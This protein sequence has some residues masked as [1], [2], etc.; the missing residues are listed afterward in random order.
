MRMFQYIMEHDLG[1]KHRTELLTTQS[2]QGALIKSLRQT[3]PVAKT[4]KQGGFRGTPWCTAGQ[5]SIFLN[6]PTD[7][8]DENTTSAS[9][10][11]AAEV[12]P[13]KAGPQTAVSLLPV[14]VSAADFAHSYKCPRGT[15]ALKR[16]SQTHRRLA[17]PIPWTHTKHGHSQE[18]GQARLPQVWLSF[19]VHLYMTPSRSMFKRTQPTKPARTHGHCFPIPPTQHHPEEILLRVYGGVGILL[20]TNT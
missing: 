1:N 18:R 7:I 10:L 12:K 14:P 13:S 8:L 9:Y 5:T 3:F 15:V 16:L 4:A 11:Q 17:G 6:F 20:T 19:R 2:T